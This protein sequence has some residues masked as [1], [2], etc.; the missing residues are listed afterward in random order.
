MEVSAQS[1][2]LLLKKI[3]SQNTN[4]KFFFTCFKV[5]E[6]KKIL[7]KYKNVFSFLKMNLEKAKSIEN[8]KKINERFD[9][10]ILTA[11]DNFMIQKFKSFKPELF[12][13]I[14]DVNLII[15]ITYYII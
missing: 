5:G 3:K 11:T 15:N 13:K 4:A 7:A 1:E 12:K 6:N 2:K 9:A 10:L 14:I 8:L